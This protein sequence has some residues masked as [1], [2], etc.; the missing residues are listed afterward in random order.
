[1]VN[2]AK[3]NGEAII[4]IEGEMNIF[5]AQ[6][7]LSS[8]KNIDMSSFSSVKLDLSKVSEIDTSGFQIIVAL[9]K[10]MVKTEKKFIIYQISEP[11]KVLF[12]LYNLKDHFQL[13]GGT[14]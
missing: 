5:N 13:N 2:I 6:E 1:M 11:V 10:S 8:L 9:E 12:D 7:L 14:K 4:S 3:E